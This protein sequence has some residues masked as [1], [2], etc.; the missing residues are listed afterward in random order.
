MNQG[1]QN[2]TR[3][4]KYEGRQCELTV[5]R[6]DFLNRTPVAQVLRPTFNKWDCMKLKASLWQDMFI[7]Y[8]ILNNHYTI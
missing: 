1:S 4:T 2:D 6:K 7:S 8:R 3:N 5:T